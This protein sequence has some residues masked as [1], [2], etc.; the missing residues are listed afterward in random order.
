MNFRSAKLLTAACALAGLALWHGSLAAQQ[1]VQR[2]AAVVNEEIISVYDLESRLRLVIITSG[3]PDN[4]ET[5]G[6]MQPQII[7]ALIDER[8]QIQE[9]ERL[10]A[11]VSEKEI[12]DAISRI[13]Q[14]N[15]MPAGTL[16]PALRDS[17]LERSALATQIKAGLAWQKVVQ[18]RL[19]AGLQVGQDEIDEVIARINDSK[20]TTEFLLAELFLAVEN[21]DQEEETR[22]RMLEMMEQMRRGAGFQAIAQQFSQAASAASGGDIGWVERG[23]IEEEVIRVLDDLPPGRATPPIRTPTGFHVYLLRDKRVLSAASPDDAVVTLA[24]LVMPVEN[25]ASQSEIDAQKELVETVRDSISGCEDMRRVARELGTTFV[26][27]TPDLR[28]GDLAPAIRPAVMP[29]K[30]GEASQPIQTEAGIALLM[31]CARTEPKSNLPDREEIADNLT[32]QRLDVVARRHL[33]DLRRQAF[34]DVRV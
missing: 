5:R 2:I 21:P 20:G 10:S 15:K 23:Q 31:V 7:R 9:A 16:I 26:D 33:R 3:M 25:G 29:L 32:R 1:G 8:L 28:I 4:A 13:E 34:I 30:A 14:A 24:Q 11:T 22:Q 6:R 12:D 19:R 27:P 18:R 17:G